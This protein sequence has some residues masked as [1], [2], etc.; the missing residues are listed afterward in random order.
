[1]WL[2]RLAAPL[3]G[4]PCVPLACT[5][6]SRLAVRET[7]IHTHIYITHIHVCVY[8]CSFFISKRDRRANICP[9]S[10]E[11]P[12]RRASSSAPPS[13][14]GHARRSRL[15]NTPDNRASHLS[16][17]RSPR[18]SSRRPSDRSDAASDS[19]DKQVGETLAPEPGLLCF[20]SIVI[21]FLVFLQYF[22]FYKKTKI[23]IYFRGTT[24]ETLSVSGRKKFDRAAE[25]GV[26]R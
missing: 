14:V 7:Y 23:T 26:F 13:V 10:R 9:L 24:K 8:V 5:R 18:S 17:E 20:T 22:F 2:G 15:R 21:T 19:A 11:P 25:S 6:E 4:F 1:M 12:P 3:Q 16:P